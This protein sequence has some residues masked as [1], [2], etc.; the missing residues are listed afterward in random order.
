MHRKRVPYLFLK[1]SRCVFLLDVVRARQVASTPAPEAEPFNG[2]RE[3]VLDKQGRP[4]S[5]PRRRDG[6]RASEHLANPCCT[7]RSSNLSVLRHIVLISDRFLML[8]GP[9]IKLD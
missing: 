7:R 4:Q 8:V 5:I 2:I 1:A 9:E 3:I 6:A